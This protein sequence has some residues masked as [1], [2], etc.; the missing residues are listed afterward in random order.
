MIET[1]D[2]EKLANTVMPHFFGGEHV[3]SLPPEKSYAELAMFLT[4]YDADRYVLDYPK[5]ITFGEYRGSIDALRACVAKVDEGWLDC[6][7]GKG[8]YY[9]AFDGDRV[10]SFCIL[11]TFGVY[12]GLT[13]AGPGC[14]G[15][16]P[17]ERG[18]RT[19]LEMIRRATAILRDEGCD[20]SYIH[21]TGIDHWY[22]RLGYTTVLRWNSAGITYRLS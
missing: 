4:D 6:Y 7:T 11:D 17:E 5:H 22:E 3:R 15:T 2:W 18:H 21:Y 9:C 16:I 10:V 13:V 8:R 12:D 19:G 20:I 14:V 1:I